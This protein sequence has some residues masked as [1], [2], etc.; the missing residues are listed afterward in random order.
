[1]TKGSLVIMK[2]KM[3]RGG[4]YILE[5][6]TVMGTVAISQ[7]LNEGDDKTELWHRRLGHM[8]KKGMSVL[9]KQG[10]LGGEATRKIKFCEACVR[11]K[12]HK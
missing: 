8:S 1:M 6:S 9:S 11:G 7:S 5:G 2:G 4:I 3:N 10:L 12:R